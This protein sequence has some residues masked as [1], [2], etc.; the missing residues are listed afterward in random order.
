MRWIAVTA[1]LTLLAACESPEASRERGGR[2]GA[3]TGNRGAVLLM[4]E[5]SEPYYKTPDLIPFAAPPTGPA[6]QAHELSLE[7]APRP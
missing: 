6:R 2:P 5:G 3:D 7:R 4:H 1:V